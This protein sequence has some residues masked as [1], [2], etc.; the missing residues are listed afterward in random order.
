MKLR[1]LRLIKLS[2]G[3][4]KGRTVE[5]GSSTTHEG[6][7]QRMLFSCSVLQQEAP[8]LSQDELDFEFGD[9]L[10]AIQFQAA[11]SFSTCLK[12]NKQIPN[13]WDPSKSSF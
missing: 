13:T 11:V 8:L 5:G 9:A 6:S 4:P 3:E 2:E 7:F 10:P 1:Q 12:R